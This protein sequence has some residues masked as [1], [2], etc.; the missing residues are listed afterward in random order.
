ME[1]LIS[2]PK[3]AKRLDISVRTIKRIIHN[4]GIET[5]CVGKRIRIRES[6]LK[7]LAPLT[8]QIDDLL[9]LKF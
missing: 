7:Y 2:L 5:Y 9:N 6:D 1:Q 8:I 4:K 3:A